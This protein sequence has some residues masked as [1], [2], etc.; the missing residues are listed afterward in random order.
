MMSP[1]PDSPTP[2]ECST[3]STVSEDRD[4]HSIAMASDLL[5]GTMHAAL[6]DPV[7]RLGSTRPLL[8][9][10]LPWQ[11]PCMVD[12]AAAMMTSSSAGTPKGP[13]VLGFFGCLDRQ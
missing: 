11:H 7:P 6:L 8:R 13:S 12:N 2:S 3:P 10:G 1:E 9:T 4:R 5:D